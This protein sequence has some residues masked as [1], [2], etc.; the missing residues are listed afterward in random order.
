MPGEKQQASSFPT[1]R[2]VTFGELLDGASAYSMPA[3][4]R[5]FQWGESEVSLLVNDLDAARKAGFPFYFLGH[6]VVVPRSD[7][8]LEVI[9]GQQRLATAS[10]LIAY[11]RDRVQ[12]SNPTL[13]NSLQNRL[14]TPKGLARL[15]LRPRD[16]RF[17]QARVQTPGAALAMAKIEKRSG[18]IGVPCE[19]DAQELIW[20]A[21]RTIH[22]RLAGYANDVLSTFAR[23]LL[24]STVVGLIHAPKRAAAAILFRGMNGTGLDLSSAD[25]MK[26]ETIELSGLKDAA[27]DDA[28]RA[29]EDC[30]DLL[31]RRRFADLLE[32]LPM[33]ITGAPLRQRA[34]L[35]EWTETLF[36][37]VSPERLLSA[38]LPTIGPILRQLMSGDLSAYLATMNSVEA[39]SIDRSV[40]L[41][42]LLMDREWQ[43]AAIAALWRRPDDHAFL[44]RFFSKLERL[45]FACFLEGADAAAW[46]RRMSAVIR[47]ITD[48]DGLFGDGGPMDIKADEIGKLVNR[49]N[50]PF[51]RES[52]RR[53]SVAI[54]ADA[55]LGGDVYLKASAFTLEHI[56]PARHSKRWEASG[57][58]SADTHHYAGLLGNFALLTEAQNQAASGMPFFEKRAVYFETPGATPTRLTADLAAH[59]TW[60]TDT[61]R[62]RTELLTAALLQDW[63]LLPRR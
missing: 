43:A 30:E 12:S 59:K 50:E 62:A 2:V 52:W 56:A 38:V 20:G 25:L 54:R 33:V 26:L 31:G 4:Q 60:T 34:N 58:R 5:P 9:D 35:T 40:K 44:A 39:K 55:A 16:E 51:K 14:L 28:V 27:L 10:I 6:I 29:W 23:F 1:A 46:E 15:T 37:A 47:Q 13:A 24:E 48:D 19:T 49:L 36:T 17:F 18:E 53:R 32:L 41:L 8:A 3:V 7:E 22:A 42:N 45:A 11:V 61:V 63:D 21:A 57:W